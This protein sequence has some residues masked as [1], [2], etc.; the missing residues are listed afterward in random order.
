MNK[1][2]IITFIKCHELLH[3]YKQT[4]NFLIALG[5]ISI[6]TAW[7]YVPDLFESGEYF[8]LRCEVFERVQSSVW[9]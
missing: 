7:F 4:L 2:I 6:S 8:T 5:F 3:Y 1:K 9:N